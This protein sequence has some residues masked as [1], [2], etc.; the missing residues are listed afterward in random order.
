MP[1]P[2]SVPLKFSDLRTEFS[3]PLSVRISDYYEGR[4]VPVGRLFK[5]GTVPTTGVLNLSKFYAK[6]IL[7]PGSATFINPVAT[8]ENNVY[9][10]PR[11]AGGSSVGSTVLRVSSTMKKSVAFTLSNFNILDVTHT[12]FSDESVIVSGFQITPRAVLVGRMLPDMTFLWCKLLT[13]STA[14]AAK[15]TVS[16]D[17]SIYITCR[18]YMWKLDANGN[19][20]QCISDSSY[21][22]VAVPVAQRTN[23]TKFQAIGNQYF[24]LCSATNLLSCYTS[25]GTFQWSKTF[26]SPTLVSGAITYAVTLLGYFIGAFSNDKLFIVHKAT[27]T[28]TGQTTIYFAYLTCL[29]PDGTIVWSKVLQDSV[30][31]A[32]ISNA[33]AIMK[34]GGIA[35]AQ[36]LRDYIVLYVNIAGT[37]GLLIFDSAGKAIR[38]A[39]YSHTS[40]VY[41]YSVTEFGCLPG[42]DTCYFAAHAKTYASATAVSSNIWGETYGATK[43]DN[44]STPASSSVSYNN[45]TSLPITDLSVKLNSVLQDSA[46]DWKSLTTAVSTVNYLTA[47][48][49]P[50]VTDVAVPAPGTEIAAP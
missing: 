32:G 14:N 10:L 26:V 23:F 47:A 33:A 50:A 37:T 31:H 34:T 30:N 7:F 17:G 40:N 46:L 3:G 4:L 20:L 5:N 19:V 27:G 42:K 28:A 48:G 38:S 11:Q 18:P 6:S 24:A 25:D 15:A 39:T 16:S 9:G 36:L 13:L 49:L 41:S 2:S 35:S 43:L 44:L 22:N 8:T 29:L 45:F 21:N 12:S 1:L